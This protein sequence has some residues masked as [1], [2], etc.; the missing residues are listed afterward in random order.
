MTASTPSKTTVS[1][2]FIMKSPAR[3]SWKN[4]HERQKAKCYPEES[5]SERVFFLGLSYL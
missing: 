2:A 3:P 4:A 1:H 5:V